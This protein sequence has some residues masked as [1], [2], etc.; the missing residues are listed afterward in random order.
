[1]VAVAVDVRILHQRCDGL[2]RGVVIAASYC[3]ALAT[4]LASVRIQC[5]DPGFDATEVDAS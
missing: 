2:Q 3:D 4:Q 1:M 5:D